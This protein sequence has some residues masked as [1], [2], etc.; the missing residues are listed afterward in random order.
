MQNIWVAYSGGVDSHLLLKILTEIKK[1]P[2]PSSLQKQGFMDS[3]FELNIKAIHIN[4]HLSKNADQWEAHCRHVC[5]ELAVEFHAVGVYLDRQMGE[6]LEACA[7]EKRIEIF[8]E[9]M[10]K[11][12]CL[13]LGHHLNDQAETVLLQL[14]RGSGVKGLAGMASFQKF[15][16]GYLMRPFLK[17]SREEIIKKAKEYQLTWIEDESNQ[18]T[19]FDRN[20]L[21]HE[22]IP[23]LEKK[24]PHVTQAIAR[25]ANNCAQTAELLEALAKID[26]SSVQH[27]EGGLSACALSL[28]SLARQNNVIRYWFEVNHCRLPS[29]LKLRHIV[30]DVVLSRYDRSPCVVIDNVQVKRIKDRIFLFRC[31]ETVIG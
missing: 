23:L 20:F 27:K 25:T 12:D 4:H 7:R 16:D 9:I 3:R 6:S 21:R 28:L 29:A 2:Y 14:M 22:V 17:I 30:H 18:S 1:I 24:R 31:L 11:G 5:T 13:M 8:S 19:H 15:A 26:F 10:K